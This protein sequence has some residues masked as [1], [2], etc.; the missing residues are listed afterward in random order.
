MNACLAKQTIYFEQA[1]IVTSFGYL[2]SSQHTKFLYISCTSKIG[3]LDTHFG[4]L[5][6]GYPENK[7]RYKQKHACANILAPR[8]A[9]CNY[10]HTQPTR[11]LSGSNFS[12]TNSPT[13]LKWQRSNY[14][15][16]TH[17]I[18][19]TKIENMHFDPPGFDSSYLYH[20]LQIYQG[21]IAWQ[22]G[23]LMDM[24]DPQGQPL[25]IIGMFRV[26]HA[27]SAFHSR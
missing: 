20:T 21:V 11:D 2:R 15:S 14:F 25:E 6:Q 18:E 4:W 8:C 19:S 1:I 26:C 24:L 27:K 23:H 17:T 10:W 5:A 9:Q 22:L 16:T 13:Y 3:C 12:P 7:M